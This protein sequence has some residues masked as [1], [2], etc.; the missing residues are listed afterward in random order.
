MELNRNNSNQEKKYKIYRDPKDV[1]IGIFL[2]Q[3]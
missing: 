1:L 2:C 3:N